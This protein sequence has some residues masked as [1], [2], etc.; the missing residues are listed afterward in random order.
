[1]VV[2]Y[3]GS[4]EKAN[5]LFSLQPYAHN[6]YPAFTPPSNIEFNSPTIEVYSTV[7]ANNNQNANF[8]TEQ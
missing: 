7:I 2:N 8:Y 6:A 1:M 4:M 3:F 5:V